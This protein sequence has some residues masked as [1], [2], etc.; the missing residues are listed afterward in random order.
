MVIS[1][2][3]RIFHVCG[4]STAF[5]K[6]KCGAKIDGLIVIFG[7]GL[8]V[9]TSALT[10]PAAFQ[11]ENV[12]NITAPSSGTFETENLI[13]DIAIT[14]IVRTKYFFLV[15]ELIGPF[16]KKRNK[17]VTTTFQK[18]YNAYPLKYARCRISFYSSF[19]RIY[20][21]SLAT[22]HFMKMR[23]QKHTDDKILF[24]M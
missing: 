20:R 21:I 10:T 9:T 11:A 2:V 8:S 24:L 18:W 6:S 23:I 15:S 4:I 16:F 17:F 14:F 12:G 5:L 19:R 1:G 3:M 13:Q 22:K 7:S